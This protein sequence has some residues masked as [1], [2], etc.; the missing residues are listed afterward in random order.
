[1]GDGVDMSK[2]RIWA[3]YTTGNIGDYG[4]SAGGNNTY[5]GSDWTL[6]EDNWTF[7]AGTD[8]GGDHTG[9]LVNSAY[10]D[11]LNISVAGDD[12]SGVQ[13][14]TPGNIP[15]PGALALLGLASLTNRRRRK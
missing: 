7:S 6:L 10:I 1:M 9:Q 13:I 8:G 11:D 4:G 15:A 3:H 2:V 14:F 12:L 5:S